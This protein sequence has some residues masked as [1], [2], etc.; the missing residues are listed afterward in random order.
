MNYCFYIWADF[1]PLNSEHGCPEDAEKYASDHGNIEAD[2]NG[3]AK[4]E[5]KDNV[6]KL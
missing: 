6:I 3:I 1:N 5:H 4:L 2:K